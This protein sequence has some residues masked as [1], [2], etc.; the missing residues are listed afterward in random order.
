M[1]LGGYLC[2]F[3]PQFLTKIFILCQFDKNQIQLRFQKEIFHLKN[4]FHLLTFPTRLNLNFFL[5]SHL[6]TTFKSFISFYI[7]NV[8]SWN[9]CKCMKYLKCEKLKVIWYETRLFNL[10]PDDWN[11]ILNGL[12]LKG[13]T[14]FFNF[15][16]DSTR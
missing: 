1:I 2:C 7:F 16:L 8:S 4:V 10:C 9:F 13:S 14:R 11:K 6:E 5:L 15:L 3:G 12:F